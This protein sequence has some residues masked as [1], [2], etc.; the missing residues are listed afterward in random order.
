MALLRS[1]RLI[2]SP[3]HVRSFATTSSRPATPLYML[4]ALSQSR[5]AQHFTKRSGLGIT[6]HSPAV[7]AIK[8]SEVDP[9]TS[10]K[11]SK[12]KNPAPSPPSDPSSPAPTSTPLPSGAQG[13]LESS[14][15]ITLASSLLSSDPRTISPSIPTD[16]LTLNRA[17]FAVLNAIP[18]SDAVLSAQAREKIQSA[19]KADRE[20]GEKEARDRAD[21]EV[22]EKSAGVVEEVSSLRNGSGRGRERE[23]G[24]VQAGRAEVVTGSGKSAGGEGGLALVAMVVAL[25]GMNLYGYEMLREERKERER[26]VGRVQR[27][28]SGRR[29]A[30]RDMRERK[31]SEAVVRPVV[32]R[33]EEVVARTVEPAPGRG[34]KV[35]GW[36][37]GLFW[38][39]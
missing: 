11:S 19:R 32:A 6:N 27:L 25:V 24:E 22:R 14:L 17:A 12:P 5:E 30:V 29:E 7:E 21:R 39:N 16:T 31:R 38:A 28:E 18:G 8:S 35:K 23:E 20:A 10:P 33:K 4:A 36:V 1:H 3:P 13:P 26:L 37:G 9:F 15:R 2:L 34:E